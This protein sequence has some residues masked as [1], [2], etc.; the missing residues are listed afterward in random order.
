MT[1]VVGDLRLL[2][3]TTSVFTGSLWKV[4]TQWWETFLEHLHPR[5]MED[6]KGLGTSCWMV[7][8]G[9]SLHTPKS[10]K[11]KGGVIFAS[12]VF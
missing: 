2:E 10:V 7:R 12:D 11:M 8:E 9:F 3:S 1:A 4:L 6:V 5:A